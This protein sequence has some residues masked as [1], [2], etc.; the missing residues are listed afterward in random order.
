MQ[1]LLAGQRGFVRVKRRVPD[2]HLEE[3]GANGP[4]VDGLVVAVLPEHLGR[5]VV[6][7]ANRRVREL[8]PLLVPRVYYFALRRAECCSRP[9]RGARLPMSPRLACA[10]LICLAAVADLSVLAEAEVG[11]FDIRII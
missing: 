10:L 4:P 1:N 3:D 11:E 9:R 2:H 7:S 6:G 8:P 5:D